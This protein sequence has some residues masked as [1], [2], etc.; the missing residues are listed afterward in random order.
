[1][2]GGPTWGTNAGKPSP[3][4]PALELSAMHSLAQF[5]QRLQRE[6]GAAGGGPGARGGTGYPTPVSLTASARVKHLPPTSPVFGAG[7]DGGVG[8]GPAGDDAAVARA[9]AC[10]LVGDGALVVS[11]GLL[12]A[13]TVTHSGVGGLGAPLD[14]STFELWDMRRRRAWGEVRALLWGA[15]GGWSCGSRGLLGV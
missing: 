2:G 8:E 13:F 9:T 4:S 10:V 6:G 3:V 11:Q 15:H 5:R 14:A 7:G 12:Y 1:M